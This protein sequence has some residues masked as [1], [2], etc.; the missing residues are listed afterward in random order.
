MHG[1]FNGRGEERT[2]SF[3]LVIIAADQYYI[4][5][6]RNIGLEQDQM[7]LSRDIFGARNNVMLNLPS[8]QIGRETGPSNYALL[9]LVHYADGNSRM[10]DRNHQP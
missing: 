5:R 3:F 6:F 4:S 7:T 8:T 1:C 10:Y 2:C 9:L